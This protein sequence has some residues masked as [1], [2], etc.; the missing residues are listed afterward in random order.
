M[1]RYKN[2]ISIILVICLS[3]GALP[4]IPLKTAYAALIDDTGDLNLKNNDPVTMSPSPGTFPNP[5]PANGQV[6]FSGKWNV[7]VNGKLAGY[8]KVVKYLHKQS[9]KA[10]QYNFVQFNKI[11]QWV[12]VFDGDPTFVNANKNKFKVTIS[13]SQRIYLRYLASLCGAYI[14]NWEVTGFE[15][16]TG[17]VYVR[18]TPRP[19]ANISV[20]KSVK[21]GTP[22]KITLSGQTFA[23]VDNQ[24]AN[25][26]GISPKQVIVSF[27]IDGQPVFSGKTIKN[28]NTYNETITRTFSAGTHTLTLF[29]KDAVNRYTR[30]DVSINVVSSTPPPPPM[31]GIQAGIDLVLDPPSLKKGTT[32]N[33]N[34]TIDAS[35]ST[36]SGN[37]PYSARFWLKVNGTDLL[38]SEGTAITGLS[39]LSLAKYAKLITNAKPGDR[40]WAKVRVWDASINKTSEAETTKIIGQYEDTPPPPEEEPMPPP[41]PEPEPPVAGINAPSEVIQGEDVRISSSSYDPD[42][43]IEDYDWRIAPSTGVV[44]TLSGKS[45]TIY[46]DNVGIYT[47]RLTV[48]DSDGLTDTAQKTIEVKPAIPKAYFDYSGA[49]K[50]NRKIILDASGSTTVKRY[51]M[52]WEAT[53]W[54][55]T[56][57]SPGLTQNDIKI[58]SSSDMKTRTV[59]F[60][61]AGDYRVRVRVKNTAGH[62]SDWFERVLTITP[63][64]PPV[65][66]FY[67]H[68]VVLRDPSNGNKAKIELMDCSYSPD[69]DIISQRIWRYK[70]DS[71][72]NGSFSDETW[73]TLDS[74]NNPNP[75]LYTTEVGKY[76]FELSIQEDFGQETIQEFVSPEDYKWD[77]T[78][79]KL[80]NEKISEV[81]NLQPTVDFEM[82]AKKKAELVIRVGKLN[83]YDTRVR[84][85]ED[86]ITNILLPIL[87]GKNIDVK[88]VDSD[89]GTGQYGGNTNFNGQYYT[90]SSHIIKSTIDTS[91]KFG[92]TTVEGFPGIFSDDN[93]ILLYNGDVSTTSALVVKINGSVYD[94]Y[95]RTPTSINIEDG[96]IVVNYGVIDG[97]E[98]KVT[99][100]IYDDKYVLINLE[101]INRASG[102]KYIGF[103]IYYD[104]CVAGNDGSPIKV[105][106]KGFEIYNNS[107]N[108]RAVGVLKN[109]PIV[110]T[111]SDWRMER[112][113]GSSKTD[114]PFDDGYAHFSSSYYVGQTYQVSDTAISLWWHSQ[115]VNP[116]QKRSVVTLLGIERPVEAKLDPIGISLSNVVWNESNAGRYVLLFSD[117]SFSDYSDDNV[118]TRFSNAINQ[119]P[120]KIIVSGQTT[121]P[122]TQADGLINLTALGGFSIRDDSINTQI[123]AIVNYIAQD[124]ENQ[125]K[126]IEQYVLLN[127][128]VE[129][130]TY[131]YDPENDPEHSE[132]WLYTHDPTYFENSLGL[133]DFSGKYIPAPITKFDKVG[134]YEVVFQKRDNPKND[135]RF[136]NYRLWSYMPLNKLTIYVHRKPI[137][138]FT[139]SMVPNGANYVISL[140]DQSYDLDHISMP[141]KG[142]Q[143]WEWKWKEVNETTWHSGK[144]SGTF[145]VGKTYIIY[146]RVQDIEGAWSDPKVQVITTQNINLPPVA[147]FTVNPATQVIN[148]PLTITDLSYD[149]NGDPIAE[150]AWRVQKPDGT[151]INYGSTLPTNI[152]SLGV[153]TYTIELKVRDNP[154]F[155]TPLWSEPY[156]QQVTVIPE[157]NKPVARFTIGP[158]PIVADEPY[159]LNDTS[160]DPDG[161]PIVAREWKV[162]KPDGTW[163]T[164]NQWKPTFEEMGLGDDGTY[165][166]QLRVLDDPSRRHPA[167][168]PMW[169]D[170]Y[171]VTVQVQGRF[172]VIG[173]SNKT[174]Y[175]AGEAMILYARTEG[176]AYRVEAKMWYPK[177]EFT[178]SNVTTLVPDTPLTSPPQ[179]VMTWHTKHTKAEGRDLVVIIPRNMPD[180]NY[181]VVFTA[182]KQ[183]AG[184]GT[185][186]ATDTITV[187]VKGTIYDHSK[188]QIIGPRF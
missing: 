121:F 34:A 179:D 160:Y 10:E 66:D 154:Q 57:A 53:E 153:G 163:V 170:P 59:L 40:V 152:P 165:K 84:Q 129:I 164:I 112:W 5:I 149:P 62:Y 19:A 7:Y 105:V 123:N 116:G 139:V 76:L 89:F 11:D 176:K 103:K 28:T 161:D 167:L 100:T 135:D 44:G 178:S 43:T 13:D 55:I 71:N 37:G 187:R 185:K 9:K 150:R 63:D 188:S 31:G 145:P 81:V 111:P 56:P 136:D 171:T 15:G 58:V 146:L 50:E 120:A 48:T 75:V 97:V 36:S 24:V 14:E 115:K 73:I 168:T 126:L 113:S 90:V 142:I 74:G 119:G 67:V 87:R 101:G 108:V 83:D 118:K 1:R 144:M 22:V 21:E 137:A 173:S 180:G 70:Y 181:Q 68:P 82:Y 134:K 38:G 143:A 157:N 122:Q 86:A 29:V 54:E 80:L 141:N 39:S 114:W 72:N 27:N 30:K 98:V 183:L 184:G 46:F 47:I 117:A 175:K 65:A 166:I 99:Y 128:E 182:Y 61:K 93:K 42:G 132:R 130:K 92:V 41:A 16:I 2:I 138:Q 64:Q 131:Y 95:T 169:S 125:G 127:E 186:T 51:P 77:D 52:I 140:T 104:T 91:G 107:Y 106:D 60:K 6:V 49:L 148:K 151:W 79:D 23:Q 35:S 17:N 162:Q 20:S 12:P 69:G 8:D 96:K 124:L 78:S 147:Q 133:A 88:I 25:R 32:G 85:L 110:T 45:G 33:V 155:G 18:T 174:T 156:T 109:N 172:I 177:N 3:I 4:V 26:V 159:T 158:N 102:E 94:L